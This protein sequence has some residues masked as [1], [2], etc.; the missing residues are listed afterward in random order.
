MKRQF[1]LTHEE[2]RIE[3]ALIRGEYVPV[4]REE[5]ERIK[6]ELD[7]RKKNAVLNIRMNQGDLMNIKSKAKKLGVKYQTFISEILH[8][9]AIS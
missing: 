1:K 5:F 8:R 9:I 2:K 6:R 3:D 7:A 4:S